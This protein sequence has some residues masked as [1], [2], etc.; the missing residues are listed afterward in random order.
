MDRLRHCG[1]DIFPA[2]DTFKYVEETTEKYWILERH[3]YYCMAL[4][5]F[6]YEM[7]TS[8]WNIRSGIRKIFFQLREIEGRKFR[9]V[10][11][12]EWNSI[13]LNCIEDDWELD[14]TPIKGRFRIRK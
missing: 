8:K 13:L 9:I 6:G 10:Y 5:A 3:I 1:L 11:T 2:F 14:M 12:D 7:Q 4:V